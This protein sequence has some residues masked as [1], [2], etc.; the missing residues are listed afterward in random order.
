M[1]V[2]PLSP[3]DLSDHPRTDHIPLHCRATHA[4]SSFRMDSL[5]VRFHLLPGEGLYQGGPLEHQGTC[6]R[7]DLFVLGDAVSFQRMER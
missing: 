6:C 5:A 7:D 4:G 2:L 3:L 1:Y